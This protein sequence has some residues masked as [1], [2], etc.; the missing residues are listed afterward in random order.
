MGQ[1]AYEKVMKNYS[2]DVLSENIDQ[3]LKKVLN[4]KDTH[5]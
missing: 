4:E 2:L 5:D 3:I 1:K